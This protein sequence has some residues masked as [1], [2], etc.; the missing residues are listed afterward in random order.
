MLNTNAHP[1]LHGRVAVA[2][3]PAPGTATN[4]LLRLQIAGRALD[5]P[6]RVSDWLQS[7]D[8]VRFHAEWDVSLDEFGLKPPSV[9][10][11]IRVGD[12]VRIEA[13]V[14]A[15][16]TNYPPALPPPKP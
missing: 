5:L 11:V 9:L 8:E 3:V 15:S 2:P 12:R 1:L 16:R 14:S 10:G 4:A 13:D 7:A 6:V